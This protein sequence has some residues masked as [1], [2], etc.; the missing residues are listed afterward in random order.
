MG[1]WPVGLSTGCFYQTSIFDCLEDVRSAGFSTIEVC[2][3]PD[4]LDYHDRN[5]VDRAAER[6]RNLEIEAYSIHAPFKDS[7]DI[8][9]PDE[10][11]WRFSVNEMLEAAAAAA[12]LEVR[13]FVI[14]PGP[15]VSLRLDR[16]EQLTRMNNAAR[17]LT[18]VSRRCR[19]EGMRL[20]LE[21]VLPHLLFGSIGDL[22]WIFGAIEDLDVGICLD[23]GH[24]HLTGSLPLVT[25]K[26]GA[27]IK[28]VHA[29]DNKSKHDDHLPPGDGEIDWT[30]FGQQ[31]NAAGFN[32]TVILELA[33]EDPDP[34]AVLQR[35]RRAR[36]FLRTL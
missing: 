24:A 14:H 23:T 17:A 27:H 26:L 15:E 19:E 9:S 33:G 29:N 7:I 35:A 5:A 12:T 22:L 3:Y 30:R 28:V 16:G 34:K 2:T 20:A 18:K 1:D 11:R 8:S 13:H 32:G 10:D 36:R 6:L 25:D 21:N 4:H 31:L